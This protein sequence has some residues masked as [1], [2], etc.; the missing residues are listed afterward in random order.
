MLASLLSTCLCVATAAPAVERPSIVVSQLQ[1]LGGVDPGTAAILTDKLVFELRKSNGFSRVISPREMGEIFTVEQ[2]RQLAGC[3][4]T[5]CLAE[6]AG[7]LD[8]DQMANGTVGLV[9][10]SRVITLS[11]IELRSSAVK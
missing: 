10:G 9:E 7:A 6:I 2:N 8:A 4:D 3:Q 11:I 5:S 1:A